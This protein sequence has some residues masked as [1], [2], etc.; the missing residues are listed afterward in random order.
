MAR[1]NNRKSQLGRFEFG[2]LKDLMGELKLAGPDT[3][4]T[5]YWDSFFNSVM[6][7]DG[8]ISGTLVNLTKVSLIG[9][10]CPGTGTIGNK[11]G[12]RHFAEVFPHFVLFGDRHLRPNDEVISS[13]EFSIDD[14]STL[15]Y[16]FDAF[17]SVIDPSPFM[18]QLVATND[19]GREVI[20][21]D[22][23]LVQYFTGKY[24]ICSVETNIGSIVVRHA[25]SWPFPSP[26][27]VRITNTIRVGVSFR[28]T[29]RFET[30]IGHMHNLRN[31]LG[32]LVGRPQ[33]LLDIRLGLK[34]PEDD[35]VFL[36]VH[37]S[38]CPTRKRGSSIDPVHPAD[39]LIDAIHRPEEFKQ[40]TSEWFRNHP[41]R[42]EPRMRFSAHSKG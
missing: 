30:A 40:V 35:P 38:H 8:F 10:I 41:A 7:E 31:Y 34:S 24:V 28:D 23:P 25:P 12:R 33:K 21:G 37:W 20:L 16:D 6:R 14:G 9:C 27:G 18:A 26:D 22:R 4:L 19:L 2:E 1:K 11:N 15:F 29:V 5:L 42:E 32:L 17:G 39:V 36:T 3:R 13:I